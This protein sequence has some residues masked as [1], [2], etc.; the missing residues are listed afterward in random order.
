MKRYFNTSGPLDAAEHYLLDPLQRWDLSA[1]LTLIEQKKYFLVHAPRQ[2]GKTTCLQAFAR[3]LNKEGKVRCIYLSVQQGQAARQDVDRGIRVVLTQLATAALGQL[4]DDFVAQRWKDALAYMGGEN[5][6]LYIL[7]QW[8]EHSKTP[9]VLLID[10]ID[11]L[12]GNTLICVLHQLRTGYCSRTLAPFPQSIVLC[13]MRHLCDYRMELGEEG[14]VVF[15][16]SSPFNINS[17]SLRLRDFS[18]DDIQALYIQH[19]QET[20]Q[21]FAAG[22]HQRVFELTQGQP[23]LVNALAYEACFENPAGRDRSKTITVADIDAAKE[24]LIQRRETH[25]HQ[26]MAKLKQ[27]RVHRVIESM[28]GVPNL[29]PKDEDFDYVTD[30][31]LIRRD[32]SNSIVIAN[33]KLTS[34][35]LPMD[36]RSK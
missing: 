24:R 29:H 30:L 26:L 13:G 34:P 4:Q 18:V 33:P 22:V 11:A 2:T 28:M 23:W 27:K 19:T 3:Y 16:E 17:K 14:K 32:E 5:A 8:C 36:L 6:L 7:N 9:L 15:A 25:L 10:E 12:V 35:Q 1:V 31:G 21:P 20:K